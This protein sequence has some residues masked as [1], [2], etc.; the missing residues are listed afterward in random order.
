MTPDQA[1]RELR[2]LYSV[3]FDNDPRHDGNY[4]D[5]TYA[6]YYRIYVCAKDHREN[7]CRWNFHSEG[8]NA[9]EV[10]LDAARFMLGHD[11]KK[12][13]RIP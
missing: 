12:I 2:A 4:A 7:Y 1:L 8:R 6:P 3:R 9:G 5:P 11:V 13:H 10:I